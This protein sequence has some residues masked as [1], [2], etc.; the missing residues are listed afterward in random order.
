MTNYMKPN[1]GIIASTKNEV[2]NYKHID[3]EP[4]KAKAIAKQLPQDLEML[5]V[6]GGQNTSQ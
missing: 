3:Y 4:I 6:N 2:K 5:S 1:V